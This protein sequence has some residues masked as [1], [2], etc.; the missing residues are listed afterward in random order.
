MKEETIEEF[1]KRKYLA[2]LDNF[3]KVDFKDGVFDGAR[4][5]AERMY[6]EEDIKSAYFSAIKSTGEGWNGE[7]AEGNN[8][9]IEDKFSE[10]FREWFEKYKNK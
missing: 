7:Y 2:R 4:W 1:A 6:S 3:E 5:Q 9:N 8:P 10:G